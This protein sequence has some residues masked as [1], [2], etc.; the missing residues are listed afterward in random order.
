MRIGN[1]VFVD[2]CQFLATSLDNLVKEM[3]KLKVVKLT[4]MIRHF[5]RNDIYFENGCYP[6]EYMTDESAG[7]NRASDEVGLLQLPGR[8]ARRRA[9]V[10]DRA[11]TSRATT[12]NR[13]MRCTLST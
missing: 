11:S 13:A 12:T 3:R 9:A 5:G 10:V 2:S 7:R 6:Y 4:N 8:Q 1:I